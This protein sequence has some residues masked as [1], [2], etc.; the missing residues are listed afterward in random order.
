MATFPPTAYVTRSWETKAKSEPLAASTLALHVQ[1]LARIDQRIAQYPK[2]C[3]LVKIKD[4]ETGAVVEEGVVDQSQASLPSIWNQND[5]R[6]RG[7]RKRLDTT[8][9]QL[10]DT[11]K[12]DWDAGA[13]NPNVEDDNQMHIT[14]AINDWTILRPVIGLRFFWIGPTQ[15]R[16][17]ALPIPCRAARVTPE[18]STMLRN[19]VGE[20]VSNLRS[21]MLSQTIQPICLYAFSP[22]FVCI[23]LTI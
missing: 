5:H 9:H 1:M 16:L 22:F 3:R 18:T 17:S 15:D 23:V 10:C 13:G 8:Y 21:R 2:I 6:A 11:Y 12:I 14:R 7:Y 20:V 4:P 19:K